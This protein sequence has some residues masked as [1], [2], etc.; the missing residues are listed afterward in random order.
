[1]PFSFPIPD[2]DMLLKLH[3]DDPEAFEALRTRL[4]QNAVD[5]APPERRNSLERLLGRIEAARSRATPQQAAIQAF[6]MMADS[7]QELRLSWQQAC[8][9]I[10]ELQTQVLLQRLR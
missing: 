10:S 5:A 6:E 3:Q 2:F 4:L 7:L 8:F 9:A 1:M